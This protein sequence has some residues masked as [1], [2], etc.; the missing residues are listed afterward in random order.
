MTKYNAVG[1]AAFSC[2]LLLACPPCQPLLPCQKVGLAAVVFIGTVAESRPEARTAQV[3]VEQVF[4][5]TLSGTLEIADALDQGGRYLFYAIL[6][7]NGSAYM[8]F[9]CSLT[10]RIEEATED[11]VFL[12]RFQAGKTDTSVSGVVDFE[13]DAAGAVKAGVTVKLIGETNVLETTTNPDGEF[14]FAQLSPGEYRVE[15]ELDGQVMTWEPE[16]AHLSAGA[17][18][19]SNVYMRVD[20][21][22]RGKVR[23]SVG[24]PVSGIFVQAVLIGEAWPVNGAVTNDDGEYE[25]EEVQAGEHYLGVGIGNLESVSLPYA[26]V[27]YPNAST[28]KEAVRIGVPAGPSILTYDLQLGPR[29]A[30]AKVR[31]NV[32]KDDGGALEVPAMIVVV[33]PDRPFASAFVKPG[34]DGIHIAELR[35]GITYEVTARMENSETLPI[36]FQPENAPI[37]TLRMLPPPPPAIP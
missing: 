25:I 36:Q 9:H 2:G 37:I 16:P 7:P 28:Q 8:S 24:A 33:R 14:A 19:Q 31:F 3:R 22:I 1:G 29:L 17:C 20:R 12:E 34:E 11:L 21:R 35:T 23:D 15:A 30:T 32:L 5:G 13:T 18:V 6:A 10:R 26:P 27:Y 4:K